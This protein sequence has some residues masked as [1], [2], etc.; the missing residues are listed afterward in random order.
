MDGVKSFKQTFKELQ[1]KK[2]KYEQVCD[3]QEVWFPQTQ[4][5]PRELGHE[6][7]KPYIRRFPNMSRNRCGQ[8]HGPAI[9]LAQP[10]DVQRTDTTPAPAPASGELVHPTAAGATLSGEQRNLGHNNLQG[11]RYDAGHVDEVAFSNKT[12]KSKTGGW[13]GFWHFVRAF[14]KKKAISASA[15]GKKGEEDEVGNGEDDRWHTV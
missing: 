9:E 2:Y 15:G 3:G 10:P 4:P 12:E 5:Q 11:R 13:Q 7:L 6:L 1:Q 14:P 8:E